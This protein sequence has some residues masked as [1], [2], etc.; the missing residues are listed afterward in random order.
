MGGDRPAGGQVA[1]GRRGGRGTG[2][3]TGCW[4]LSATTRGRLA[5][6][7]GNRAS[8]TGTRPRSS[9]WPSENASRRCWC[10]SRQVP[11]A[12]DW[13]LEHGSQTGPRLARVLGGFWLGR[14]LVQEGRDWLDRALA[15]RPADPRLR[16]DLLRLLGASC[17]RPVTWTGPIRSCRRA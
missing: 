3:A 16:A 6:V 4:T 8:G 12:L 13:S 9:P 15:R 2:P 11:A 5:E 7:G 14:G 1:G 10:A 17:S